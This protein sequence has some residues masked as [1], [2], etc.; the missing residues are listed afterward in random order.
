MSALFSYPHTLPPGFDERS[1]Y[2]FYLTG[3]GA[4]PKKAA[5]DAA[6]L[7]ALR[8]G[9]VAAAVGEF[10]PN[11]VVTREK[12]SAPLHQFFNEQRKLLQERAPKLTLVK[13]GPYKIA[14]QAAHQAE[15]S[16]ALDN[17]RLSLVQW[18]VVTVRDGFAY[19]FFATTTK[20]RWDGDRPK[21][22]AFIA[23]WK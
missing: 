16:A 11:M 17:P 20:Q 18:Q 12:T 8:P 22:E 13:E 14:G 4:A 2:I 6:A 5:A 19:C 3:D 15:L 7:G 1:V 23:G 9:A 10:H 21:F